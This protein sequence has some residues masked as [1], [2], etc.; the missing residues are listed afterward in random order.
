MT[1][2][3]NGRINGI[4][5]Q[6]KQ[7]AAME[8]DIVA[9]QEVKLNT[10]PIFRA[11]FPKQ[12]LTYILDS[13]ELCAD[14]SRLVG[15]RKYGQLIASRWPI[16]PLQPDRFKIPWIERVLSAIV[17]APFGKVELHTTHI[18]PG[19]SNGWIKI[20]TLEGIFDRLACQSDLPR[21]L[22]GDFNTPK[23]ETA[24]GRTITWDRPGSRW[25]SGERNV[26]VGLADFDLVE[27]Y[28][29]IYGYEKSDFSW[30]YRPHIGRRFDHVFA[31]RSLLGKA[32]C[33]Y[34]HSFRTS[35]LSDHSALIVDF[36]W[37]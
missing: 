23:E 28:R 14:R 16:Q 30:F 2:N 36:R 27:V 20:E 18:P 19:S 8:C 4:G 31:S 29:Y 35:K 12:G 13:F 24:D 32:T 10:A 6:V 37:S 33:E 22:C 26:L 3:V 21:I 25:D 1:W 5:A 9:L 11:E 34:N 15:P 7:I 17:D